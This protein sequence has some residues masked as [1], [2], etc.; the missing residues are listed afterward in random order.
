[1][2]LQFNVTQRDGLLRLGLVINSFCHLARFVPASKLLINAHKHLLVGYKLWLKQ[3]PFIVKAPV[4]ALLLSIRV[5]TLACSAEIFYW[6]L[7]SSPR[8]S[9]LI[10]LFVVRL[11][12]CDAVVV[13]GGCCDNK[14]LL[15]VISIDLCICV[16][17]AFVKICTY[18]FQSSWLWRHSAVP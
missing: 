1:M 11:L 13:L 18:L 16:F 8:G 6:R 9:L 17:Y 4:W 5:S 3:F 14:W 2:Q 15:S 10:I 12:D 7:C